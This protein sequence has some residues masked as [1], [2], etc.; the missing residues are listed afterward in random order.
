[1][2]NPYGRELET[3]PG[4]PFLQEPTL[5]DLIGAQIRASRTWTVQLFLRPSPRRAI[6]GIRAK[7]YDSKGFITFLNQRDLEVLLGLGVPGQLCPWWGGKY[8]E[9]GS[10]GW[11]GFCVDDE[12]LRDDI[13]ER[14]CFIRK[15][16]G[17]IPEGLSLARRVHLDEGADVEETW[18]F[19]R[20]NDS[21]CETVLN[22]WVRAER[23]KVSWEL[24]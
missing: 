3:V 2:L 17:R 7:L 24:L 4:T 16:L 14:E 1:M 12:D 8:A 20:D 15:E 21:R 19:L 10:A 11:I 22:R 23:A 6:G 9:P 18:V 13:F 5:A